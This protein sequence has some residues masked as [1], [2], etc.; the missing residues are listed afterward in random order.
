MTRY[1]SRQTRA[2]IV[3]LAIL[4][5][6]ALHWATPAG[7]HPWH[8]THLV[9]EKLY[10]VPLLLAAA[11]FSWRGTVLAT[12]GASLLYL[13]HI[14]RNWRGSP[15]VQAEQAAAISTFWLM[16]VLARSLFGRV[17]TALAELHAAHEDTL[18]AL[19]SSL[20]L[21]ERYTAGHS[22]RVRDYSLLI[23]ERLS[24]RDPVDLSNLAAGA[25]FHDIGKIGIPDGILL[26]VAPLD[27]GEWSEM[28][29]HPELGA[30]LI[31]R[32]RFLS[33][34]REL[35][36]SHHERYD[37]KGYPRRLSGQKIPLG[38][39]IFA[40][41]DAFDAMTTNRPYRQ[42][43]AFD[44]ARSTL[45]A[46]KGSQF[47]PRVVEAFLGIPVSVLAKIAARHGGRHGEAKAGI[48]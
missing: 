48:G 3:A 12:L 44:D 42:A 8:W 10:F 46:G 14:V 29:R 6:T 32:I 16:A 2:A 38:A 41:A 34:A 20:E 19:A 37:G 7:S 15:M 35:V 23:A 24:I 40:V 1:D 25:R 47:D 28:R 26:K 5:T 9:A 45:S 18:T 33:Q 31:G 22:E 21:R 36:L 13:S 11:W 43:M 17:R 4:A 27:P 30:S 39:R